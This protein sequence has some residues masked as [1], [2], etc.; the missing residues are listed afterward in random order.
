MLRLFGRHVGKIEGEFVG[1]SIVAEGIALGAHV[2]EEFGD[3]L[4]SAQLRQ[5]AGDINDGGVGD[6][7]TAGIDLQSEHGIGVVRRGTGGV[8]GGFGVEEALNKIVDLLSVV[9][10][11][12]LFVVEQI[13]VERTF[14]IG[15]EFG[16]DEPV[17]G[18]GVVFGFECGHVF[19][20]HL[21]ELF[22]VV[23]QIKIVEIGEERLFVA[24]TFLIGGF[25]SG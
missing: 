4:L 22:F 24:L 6:V 19:L 17:F 25:E 11:E 1:R 13:F 18:F 9:F 2:V 14:A 12:L 20:R 15:D 21:V 10:H 3:A 16:D 5:L 7:G 8:T 23:S